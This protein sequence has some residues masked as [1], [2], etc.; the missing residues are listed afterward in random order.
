MIAA[1]HGR[2]RG[3]CI[4]GLGFVPGPLL[5]RALL[6]KGVYLGCALQIRLVVSVTINRQQQSSCSAC[7][8]GISVAARHV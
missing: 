6:G 2:R 1:K 4:S 5:R 7:D 3:F 8:Y